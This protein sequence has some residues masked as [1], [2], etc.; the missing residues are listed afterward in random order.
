M[1]SN[2]NSSILLP[3]HTSMKDASKHIKVLERFKTILDLL[4]YKQRPCFLE[5]LG[6]LN[7]LYQ[8]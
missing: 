6:C 5:P 1:G 7:K 4:S 3:F 8:I 2:P